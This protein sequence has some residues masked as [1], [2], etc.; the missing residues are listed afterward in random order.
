MGELE[1]LQ[2]LVAAGSDLQS[3]QAMRAATL[4]ADA[5]VPPS[6]KQG[7]LTAFAAK[8]ETA[9]EVAAFASAFRQMA[10]NPRVEAWADRAIDVCGTGGD[11]SSTFNISTAVSFIVAAAGVPVFKHGNRSITSTC[12]SAD[13]LEGLGFRL[14]LSHEQL[15]QCLEEL[16]FCFFFAPAFHPAFKEIMPVRKA[17]AAAGQR[18]I[19]NLLGPLINPGRPAH[20]LL[21]VFAPHWVEPLAEALGALELAA[22]LVVHGYPEEGRALDELSCAGSNQF[23]GFGKLS[24]YSGALSA[25][26]V[27]LPPCDLA[28]LVG[29][30]LNDNLAILD[31]VLSGDEG[32]VPLGLRNSILLNAGAALWASGKTA[33]LKDGIQTAD[34]HLRDGSVARWLQRAQALNAQFESS[35]G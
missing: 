4:L 16:D 23:S 17:M 13:L 12:G 1:E 7:F 9:E 29:G 19:F 10:I 20:Q 31:S 8:G 18:S 11:G 32:R 34:E 6:A 25:N 2:S 24:K 22:G 28:D 27:G 3:S 33:D 26:D 35:Y 30:G 15:R 5:G 21:G 14:D